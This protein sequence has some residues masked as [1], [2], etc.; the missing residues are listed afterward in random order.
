[1]LPLSPSQQH[2]AP[3]YDPRAHSDSHLNAF[4]NVQHS[5]E[6]SFR[7][8]IAIG[9]RN[10]LGAPPGVPLAARVSWSCIGPRAAKSRPRIAQ[11]PPRA[12][13]EPPKSRAEP[14]KTRSHPPP[15]PPPPLLRLSLEFSCPL[16][17][18]QRLDESCCPCL[19]F[20]VAHC[21]SIVL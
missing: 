8:R 7:L 12:A 13:Q 5:S 19:A 6:K 21:N 2:V 10:V 4:F 11:E 20:A 1:M 16:G 15:H 18:H 3:S 14:P 9:S 17:F